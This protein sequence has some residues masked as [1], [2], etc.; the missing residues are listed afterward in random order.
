MDHTLAVLTSFPPEPEAITS[1]KQYD[2]FIKSY[3]KALGGLGES[4]RAAILG[5]ANE[6]LQVRGTTDISYSWTVANFY[7]VLHPTHN[8]IGYLAVLDILVSA[9]DA[10][11]SLNQAELLDSVLGFLLQ[12][13]P[14]QIRY[15]APTF[16][17]LLEWIGTGRL[18][19][20]CLVWWRMISRGP[21][22]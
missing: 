7:Q 10:D 21:I 17:T 16:L 9:S 13:D 11:R 19:S 1:N 6:A 2:V 22:D 8:S 20:V 14:Y 12:F 3:L 4:S 15:M 18:F 5:N